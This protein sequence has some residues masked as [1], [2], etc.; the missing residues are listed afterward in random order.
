MADP[1]GN[2]QKKLTL[3]EVEEL[4]NEFAIEKYATQ[5]YTLP[6]TA[7]RIFLW[8]GDFLVKIIAGPTARIVMG[9]LPGHPRFNDTMRRAIDRVA[10]HRMYSTMALEKVAHIL[11]RDALL[12]RWWKEKYNFEP[13]MIPHMLRDEEVS[14]RFV[15]R[16]EVVHRES[17][18]R[19]VVEVEEGHRRLTFAAKDIAKTRLARRVHAWKHKQIAD[20]AQS[21]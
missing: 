20:Q 11:E 7:F 8:P 15:E 19:E 18:M 17:G 13:E 6:R 2:D 21:A 9:V 1:E 12:T 3:S 16:V 4:V 10:S 14:V 5:H